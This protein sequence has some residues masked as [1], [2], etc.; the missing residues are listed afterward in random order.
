MTNSCLPSWVVNWQTTSI[1]III[2]KVTWAKM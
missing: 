2:L 1:P